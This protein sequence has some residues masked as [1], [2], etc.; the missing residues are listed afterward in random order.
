MP[1]CYPLLLRC[2]PNRIK[3]HVADGVEGFASKRRANSS[4][5]YAKSRPTFGPTFGPRS[6]IRSWV[7]GSSSNGEPYGMDEL[8]RASVKSDAEILT[9]KQGIY[10]RRD[11]E[12]A[13]SEEIAEAKH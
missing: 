1:F 5:G 10:V 13:V 6:Q 7:H 12:V 11:Y 9:D 2:I 4:K 8:E 3:D